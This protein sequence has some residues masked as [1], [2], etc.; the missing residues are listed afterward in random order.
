MASLK[1]AA[2]SQAGRDWVEEAVRICQDIDTRAC[3]KA[4]LHARQVLTE[5]DRPYTVF[6]SRVSAVIG[7]AARAEM[8]FGQVA[9]SCE[10]ADRKLQDFLVKVGARYLAIH[11]HLLQW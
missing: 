10:T 7:H 6:R 9:D 1:E 2:R 8:S 5:M 3:G 11:S 4:L